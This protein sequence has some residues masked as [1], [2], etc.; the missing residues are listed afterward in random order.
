LWESL[1]PLRFNCNASGVSLSAIVQLQGTTTGQLVNSA[2]EERVLIPHNRTK[3]VLS[4]FL[5]GSLSAFLASAAVIVS[6]W[7]DRFVA[8][9]GLALLGS[10]ALYNLVALVR[11]S[12]ALVLDQRG[13][14]DDHGN[15]FLGAM[16]WSEIGEARVR[17]KQYVV[18]DARKSATAVPRRNWLQW[19]SRTANRWIVG[20]E[21][22]LNVRNL[23]V[24]AEEL[25]A[26]INRCAARYRPMP[27]GSGARS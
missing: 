24:T 10:L 20:G 16:P 18:I 26:T 25:A 9:L 13:I 15:V 17:G 7:H 14:T 8:L 11:G 6:G 3:L 19:F 27:S 12:P 22:M 4:V 5:T 1:W 23:A 2:P 21:I